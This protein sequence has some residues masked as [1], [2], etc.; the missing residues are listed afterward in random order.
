MEAPIP[1]TLEGSR[2]IAFTDR[3]TVVAK[4][5]DQI[6]IVVGKVSLECDPTELIYCVTKAI[7]ALRWKPDSNPKSVA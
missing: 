3:M 1:S 5:P 2:V 4:T 6:T 7:R